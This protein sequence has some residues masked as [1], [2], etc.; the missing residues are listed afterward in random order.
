MSVDSAIIVSGDLVISS[1]ASSAGLLVE[2]LGFVVIE[3]GGTLDASVAT[4]QG[5]I[6]VDAGGLLL[7]TDVEEDGFIVIDGTAEGLTARNS[8]QFQAYTGG[9]LKDAMLEEGGQGVIGAGATAMDTNVAGGYFMLYGGTG[10]K[11]VV[12]SGGSFV[13][14]LE[15]GKANHT[16]VLKGGIMR[17][18]SAGA[19][20]ATT[21]SGGF[22]EVLGGSAAGTVLSGGSMRVNPGDSVQ[23]TTVND[24]R[25]ELISATAIKTIV[26]GAEVRAVSAS[27]LQDLTMNGGALTLEGGLLSS[28]LVDSGAFLSVSGAT[29]SDLTMNDEFSLFFADASEM[30]D[31]T[32]NGGTGTFTGVTANGFAAGSEAIVDFDSA[33]MIFGKAVFAEGATVALAGTTVTF[34]TNIATAT[35]A[36]IKGLSAVTGDAVYTLNAGVDVGI[37]L[38]AT[39]ADEFNSDVVFGQYTLRLNEEPLKV[40]DLVYTLNLNAGVLDLTIEEYVPPTPGIVTLAY[41]N[42]EWTGLADGTEVKIGSTMATIGTNAF[43]TGDAATEAVAEVENGKV[44]VA[45]G[46]VNFAAGVTKNTT[47]YNGAVITNSDVAAGVTLVVNNG[48]KLTGNAAFAAGSIITINGTLEFDTQYTAPEKAQFSGFSAVS[49]NAK[50]TLNAVAVPGS[51]LLASDAAAFTGDVTF[52]DVTLTVGADPVVIDDFSYSLTITDNSELALIVVSVMPPELAYVNS[53][54]SDKKDGDAIQI[55]ETVTAT[56]GYDAFAALAPAEAAAAEDGAIEI[57]G[58][59][60]SFADG[61]TKPITVDAGAT[62]VGKA[63]FDKA[64]TVDGTIAFD[65]ANA[66]AEKAQFGGFSFI[67]GSTTT[68]YTLTAE[69]PVIGTYLLASDAADFTGTVAFG[70]VALTVGAEPVK[71]GNFTYALSLTEGVLALDIAEYIPPTPTLAYVNSEWSGK[72]PGDTVQISGETVTATIGYD[73][74]ALLAPAEAAVTE[75]GAIEVVGGKVSFDEGYTK[76]I[77]VDTGA[78]VVGKAVFDKAITIDGTI[79][80]DIAVATAEA[81]QFGGFAFITGSTSTAYTLT[82]EKPAV[83]TYLLASGLAAPFDATVAFGDVTLTVGAEPVAVGQF[84]YALTMTEGTLTLEIAKNIPTLAY[85]NSLWSALPAGSTVKVGEKNATIGYD[86][87]AALAPAETAVTEDGAVEIAG[88]A[89]SFAE[90]YTRT[91]TVDAAAAVVGKAVF[92]KAITVNGTIA[93]DIANATAEAAQFGGF[94]FI[95]GTAAYTLTAAVP[96]VGTYLLA[97]EVTAFTGTVKFGPGALTIGAAPTVIGDFTYALSLTEGTLALTID[98]Y[99]PPTPTLDLAYVNSKWSDKKEGDTVQISDTVTATVGVNAFASGDV[100]IANVL[101][102]GTLEVVGGEVF[103]TNPVAKSVTIDAGATL[104]GKAAFTKAITV[105]GTVAFDTQYA[106]AEAAQFTDFSFVTGSTSTVYTLTAA[107]PV[108]GTY[109]LA[110]NAAA[111][112]GDV[113]FG[114][115]TLTVGAEAVQV[116]DFTYALGITDNNDLALRVK[117]VEPDPPTPVLTLTYVNSEWA[118]KQPGDTVQISETVTATIGYDAFAALAPAEAAIPDDG[119]VEI[120]GGL[121]SFAEG[122]SRTITVDADATVFGKAVFDK[123]IT[124]NGTFAFDIAN[125]TAEEAQ[126]GGFSFVT[127]STTTAYTLTAAEPVIGTYMLASDAASFDSDVL[128]NDITLTV[129][130][131]PVQVGEF[132]LALNLTEG[133]LVLTIAEYIPPAPSLAYVNSEWAELEDGT[134]VQ[135]GETGTATIGYD[136]FAALAPAE[137]AVTEDGAVEITGGSISFADGYT[138]TITVDAEAAVVG[139]AAFDKAITI[140]GTVAFDTQFATAE[141]AQFGGFSFITGST[142]TAYTLTDDAPAVGTYLLATD[143]AGFNSDVTF[144]DVTLTVGAEAVRVG[145]FTYAL[146]LNEGVLALTVEE[147]IPPTPTLAYVNSE[148]AGLADKTVVTVGEKTAIIGYDAFSELA[149]AIAAVTDTGAVEVAGGKVSFAQGYSKTIT[150]DADA[151]VVGK[152]TFKTPITINGT[153]AFDTQYMTSAYAQFATFSNI[154]GTPTYTLTDSIKAAGTYQLASGAK[155]FKGNIKFSVYTLKTGAAP[156]RVGNFTYAVSL[157]GGSLSLTVEKAKTPSSRPKL[158]YV[159]SEWANLASGTMVK[160]NST[161]YAT[162]GKDAF[163]DGDTAVCTVS[164]KGGEIQIVGGSASFTE[165][166]SS[167]VVS[168]G[169]ALNLDAPVNL[170]DVTIQNGGAMTA[171]S[172]ALVNALEFEGSGASATVVMGGTVANTCVSDGAHITVSQGGLA[173]DIDL[174]GGDTAEEYGCLSVSK[175]GSASGITVSDGGSLTTDDGSYLTRLTVFGGQ[176]D[177]GGTA[178][179]VTLYDAMNVTGWGVV[180][181]ARVS[182]GGSIA[183]SNTEDGVGSVLDSVILSGGIVRNAG[184]VSEIQVKD[185]GALETFDRGIAESVDVLA[186]GLFTISGSAAEACNLSLVEGGTVTVTDGAKLTG[187]ITTEDGAFIEMADGTVLEFDLAS[188]ARPVDYALVSDFSAIAGLPD[189]VLSVSDAQEGGTYL[190]AGGADGFDRGI[191]FGEYTLTLDSEPVTIGSSTFSLILTDD[192]I[193]TLNIKVPNYYVNTA[194]AEYEDGT[195]VTVDGVDAVIGVDAF[196]TGDAA[197]AASPASAR[198]LVVGGTVSFTDGIVKQTVIRNGAELTNTDVYATLFLEDGAVLSG[199]SIIGD[200]AA[201]LGEGSIIFNSE[202]AEGGQPQFVGLSSVEGVPAYVL[203]SGTTVGNYVFATDAADMRYQGIQVADGVTAYVSRAEFPV[204]KDAEGKQ[205]FS[206]VFD[207]TKD[208]ELTLSVVKVKNELD[209]GWNNYVYDKKTK[210]LNPLLDNFV[211]TALEDGVKGILLDDKGT[212]YSDGRRNYVGGIKGG[213]TDEYDYAKI[214]LEKSARLSLNLESTGAGKFTIWQL[215]EGTDKKGNV[216]YTMKSLQ[217]TTLKKDKVTGR[218]IASS[219]DLLIEAGDYYISMQATEAASKNGSYAFYNAEINC[220]DDRTHFFADGDNGWNNYVYDKKTKELSPAAIDGDLLDNMVG[221]VGDVLQLDTPAAEFQ[222][223]NRTLTNFVGFGD[224]ADYAKLLLP[225]DSSLVFDVTAT[226]AAK[227][228]IWQLVAD[229]DKK[230]TVT[231]KMKEIQTTALKKDKITG[232]YSVETKELRLNLDLTGQYYVSVQS[233][234]A[235][236]GGSAYY[237]VVTSDKS[238]FYTDADNGWNDYVYDKKREEPLN[239]ALYDSTGT[240]LYKKMGDIQLDVADTVSEQVG[241]T[242]F[243]NFVG[244]GDDADYLKITL[245]NTSTLS[246][247]VTATNA[248]KFVIYQLVEGVDKKG[249]TTYK[250][251]EIQSTTLKKAD[252]YAEF[253]TVTGG[254]KPTKALE[255]GDY[256]IAVIATN[257]KK[258]ELAYYNV[259]LNDVGCSN[260]PD[261]PPQQPVEEENFTPAPEESEPGTLENNVFT[262]DSSELTTGPD[263]TEDNLEVFQT[264]SAASPDLSVASIVDVQDSS[265]SALQA[266]LA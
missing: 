77:T 63:V 128:F 122:Y 179:K 226:D 211:S 73:A 97:T 21:L 154:S 262:N 13:V 153:I 135:I 117:S 4:S 30:N 114:N 108:A 167:I 148:W 257:A 109:L 230:G 45:G 201:V 232:L 141:T 10:E 72:L 220:A 78:T 183:T 41:A 106:T 138:K 223:E 105:D 19:A 39:D 251:K 184:F 50:Y 231:Y 14:Q 185:G 127:G 169:A 205:Q 101:A 60:I 175:G 94:S 143:A 22:L 107:N 155:G 36:Q 25:L 55:S 213:A 192:G 161:T 195:V 34:D 197:A 53:E 228:T 15:T 198:I 208:N 191:K 254:T 31:V 164:P 190:L 136:A 261:Q 134:T 89:I 35:E 181:K 47:V 69:T 229:V 245:A 140:E 11:T 9:A 8:G 37:Y 206:Y 79:A 171:G 33:S 20:E 202:Y 118:E 40:G 125:A 82:A 96:A 186:G 142:S 84:T 210:V 104:I 159:N 212:V 111:F 207:V 29:I 133:N 246:F 57:V 149:T 265:K 233:T 58:G 178:T 193:L 6:T 3:N 174:S 214:T 165:D 209:N 52:G 242:T 151:T 103:F 131:E 222:L 227:F 80:F 225:Y 48:A 266:M 43:A 26:N 123:P 189:L 130:A 126:F 17:L 173:K 85:V 32:V 152:A 71:V 180:S 194:W 102:E 264:A 166:A 44:R 263:S 177:I 219:K 54:W 247:N 260:L 12:S 249:V 176:A 115:V 256:Y 16:T 65:I 120:V 196:A 147:Y 1:G 42:S 163:A 144:G 99:V 119:A 146:S 5:M 91:I 255:A 237:S 170:T 217:A 157:M 67:T 112:T 258:G 87:F 156:I 95:S 239:K 92:D 62:V 64:I 238:I 49:G 204:L 81:A 221:K 224:D 162:L 27:T 88:G 200:K 46:T 203:A 160:V 168:S 56:F 243:K 121:I 61:Y 18:I 86:A 216:T 158:V 244:Y 38:L 116:G 150:V 253:F 187:R 234:N 137:A 70:D 113:L 188:L 145:D 240:Y 218:Y 236:K 90:G 199:K 241:G 248:A 98:E 7:N 51:Y 172:G 24:G 139:S 250:M 75:D 132:T 74:F 2:G 23:D 68:A 76:T 93:F 100:A 59:S 83:G 124:V 182:D 110:S 235:S 129:G 252:K 66:T 215:V 259:S 28:A